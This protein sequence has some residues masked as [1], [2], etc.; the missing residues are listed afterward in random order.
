CR[1]IGSESMST[2][3]KKLPLPY[4]RSELVATARVERE[5]DLAL[6]WIRHQRT[7]LDVW[8]FSRRVALGRGL[9]ALF[10]GEPG[11]GK[12]MAAQ[13]LARDLGLEIFRVDLS[14]V[15]SKYIGET[16]KNLASLFDE[17]RAS[18]AILFFDEADALFG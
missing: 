5:L 15:M 12:T 10:A 14:R 4:L 9:T 3:A 17:S 6:A 8:G 11:T 7:V 16:E 1:Q 2:L 13:V 18:G